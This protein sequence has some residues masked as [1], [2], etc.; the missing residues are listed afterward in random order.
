MQN[1][2]TYLY[3]DQF[4]RILLLSTRLTILSLAVVAVVS[5]LIA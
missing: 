2:M 1:T 5:A 4:P 3:D